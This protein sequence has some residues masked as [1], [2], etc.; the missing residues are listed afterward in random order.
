MP[1]LREGMPRWVA[2]VA[3][4]RC[5]AATRGRGSIDR[6]DGYSRRHFRFIPPRGT[7]L[8]I[9][10]ELEIL[11]EQNQ[12]TQERLRDLAFNLLVGMVLVCGTTFLMMGWQ[13]SLWPG[14]I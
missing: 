11:F 12:Y 2:P 9:G 3:C 14:R 1:T 4:N 13:P 10:V 7:Q 6:T 8:P 5:G